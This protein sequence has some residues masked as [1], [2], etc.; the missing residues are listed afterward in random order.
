MLR[1]MLRLASAAAV[2]LSIAWVYLEPRFE[3]WIALAGSTAALI[4]L[5][6]PA[7]KASKGAQVQEVGGGSTAFQAGRDIKN[8]KNRVD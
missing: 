7:F 1:N 3:S 4:G 8:V 5:F 6:V 2:V